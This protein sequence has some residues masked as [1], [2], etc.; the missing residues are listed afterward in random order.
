MEKL[1]SKVEGVV[2]YYDSH[3]SEYGK[4]DEIL[5]CGG[6]ANIQDIDKVIQEKTLIGTRLGNAFTNLHKPAQIS[7]NLIKPQEIFVKNFIETRKLDLASIQGGH[8][9]KGD[10]KFL[11]VKQDSSITYVT[12]IGLAL[13]SIFID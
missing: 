3:F 4:L 8:S 12:A 9:K 13:R 2:K 11:S 7:I 5:L 10:K 6:G 1:V